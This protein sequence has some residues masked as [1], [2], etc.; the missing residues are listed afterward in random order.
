MFFAF[1]CL[2]SH[3]R[4][5]NYLPELHCLLFNIYPKLLSQPL[6]L[7]LP[8][9]LLISPYFILLTPFFHISQN[10][11]PS[12]TSSLLL[13]ATTFSSFLAMSV[14]KWV[15]DYSCAKSLVW[16]EELL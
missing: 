14:H 3:L 9:I 7:H 5:K 2:G 11:L 15:T 13:S 4:G 10:L 6:H 16:E 1:Q 8:F 12:D